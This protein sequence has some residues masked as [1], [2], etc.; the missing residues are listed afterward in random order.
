MTSEPNGI[1]QLP[2]RQPVSDIFAHLEAQDANSGG[3]GISGQSS[4]VAD[5]K[6][7]VAERLTKHA[8]SALQFGDIQSA[9]TALANA[10]ETL[11]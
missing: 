9:R 5:D 2:G 3:G 4:A 8:L 1:V 6:V 7:I 11:N 10:L